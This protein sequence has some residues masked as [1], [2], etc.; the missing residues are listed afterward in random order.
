MRQIIL[1]T[2]TTGLAVQDGHRIVE[3]GCL[4]IVN[5]RIT[6]RNLHL[7]VNPERAIDAGAMA[8]HGITDERV[9]AEP[10]F[11]EIADQVLAFVSGAEVLIHNAAFDEA[12]LDAELARCDRGRFRDHVGRI[13]DT[14]KMARERHSGKRN[15]LDTLCERYGVSNAH[16]KLHGALLDAELLADVFL[17]MTRG[18]DSLEMAS[19][20]DEQPR[21]VSGAPDSDW[22]PVG[23]SV[24][25]AGEA[26][27]QAHEAYMSVLERESRRPLVWADVPRVGGA[28]ATET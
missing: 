2:E 5:R 19:H 24:L 3:I 20:S 4:E 15:S 14:L 13:V 28:N 10:R 9:Q 25:T 8:V 6:G 7:Y 16:R 26:D 1:D 17:A 23:L 27:R 11:A 21:T 12:F 18:Q 22:P